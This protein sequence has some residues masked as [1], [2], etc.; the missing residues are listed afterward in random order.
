MAEKKNASPIGDVLKNVLSRLEKEKNLSKEDLHL[1]DELIEDHIFCRNT[2]KKLIIV[3]EQYRNGKQESLVELISCLKTLVEFYPK[4]I[5]KED[6][7]FFLATQNYFSDEEDQ[8]MLGNFWDFDRN[9]IHEKYKA[10]VKGL[11]EK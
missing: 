8:A 3:N 5:K 9:M 2:T 4:H 6:N 1:M 7:V 11:E 10:V